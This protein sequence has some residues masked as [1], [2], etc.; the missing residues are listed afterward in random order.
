MI[1]VKIYFCVTKNI[2]NLIP[3]FLRSGDSIDLLTMYSK[4]LTRK[5]S[6]S[7]H[8]ISGY[9]TAGINIVKSISS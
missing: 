8:Q 1:P 5:T 6:A 9:T 7:C 4:D 3:V 2:F